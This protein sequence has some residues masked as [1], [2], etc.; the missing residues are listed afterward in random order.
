MNNNYDT[1][2]VENEIRKILNESYVS[3]LAVKSKAS[4]NDQNS[5]KNLLDSRKSAI[6]NTLDSNVR[7]I[8]KVFYSKSDVTNTNDDYMK[9]IYEIYNAKEEKRNQIRNF[10]SN[11]LKPIGISKT[12]D[13][14]KESKKQVN[15]SQTNVYMRSNNVSQETNVASNDVETGI[16][17]LRTREL[18]V[19]TYNTLH[20]NVQYD[21]I[22]SENNFNFENND[23]EFSSSDDYV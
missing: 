16:I 9:S 7:S 21:H 3:N 15:H 11:R 18:S 2:E 17:N 5:F 23:L 12:L 19:S 22:T 13:E 4:S 6:K 1:S 20:E 14:F 10:G 8:H